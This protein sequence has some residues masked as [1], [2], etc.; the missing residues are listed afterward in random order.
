MV[1]GLSIVV[2]VA[3]GTAAGV[4]FSVAL[5][6]VP[7]FLALS[8]ERY[9]EMHKLIGRRY[10]RVMPPTVATAVVADIVLASSG[11]A[12]GTRVLF[13]AAAILGIGVMAVSQFGNVPINRQV[14]SINQDSIP[15]GWPDPRSR[16]RYLHLVRTW[17]AILGFAVNACAV[18]AA[19]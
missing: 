11:A 14:K 17:F 5:S 8:P 16:W 3:S 13:A 2:L 10:D 6:V 4:L 15:G 18:V 9:V 19:R 1:V 7:A 12:I